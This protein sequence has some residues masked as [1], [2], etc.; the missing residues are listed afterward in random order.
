MSFKFRAGLAS[1]AVGVA[2]CLAALCTAVPPTIAQ[3]APAAANTAA[4]RKVV[5]DYVGLYRKDTLAAWRTLFLPTFTATSPAADGTVTV[6]TLDEFYQSQARG[7]ARA[8]EMS[9]TLENVV[10]ERSGRM[11]TA[12]ADF[13][14]RQNGSARRG[15]LVLTLVEAK[16]AWRIAAVMFSY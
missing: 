3:V 5:D 1:R 12:W 8:A 16:G 6:R 15:R 9:E 11:A 2:T 14:F 4:V 7:F 13:V 10:I